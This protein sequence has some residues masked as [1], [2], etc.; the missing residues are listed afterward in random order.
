[1]AFVLVDQLSKLLI[2]KYVPFAQDTRNTPSLQYHLYNQH[3]RRLGI[4]SGKG[5]LLMAIAWA[6]WRA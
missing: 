1:L 2:V 3:G 6:S 5:W 4:F